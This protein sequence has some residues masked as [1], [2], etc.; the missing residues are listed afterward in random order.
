MRRVLLYSHDTFGLGHLRRCRTIAQALTARFDDLSALIVTGSPVVGRFDFGDRI[1]HVR[2]PGVV[3]LADGSYAAHNLG[4]GLDE[5]VDLRGSILKATMGSFDPNIV[6]VDKEPTGFKGELIPTLEAMA[7]RDDRTVILGIRDVLDERN[8]LALEWERK[9]AIDAL[10]A[11]YDEIW[12]YGL[13]EIYEPMKGLPLAESWSKRT[14]YTGYLRRDMVHDGSPNPVFDIFDKYILVTP[15]GGGDGAQ[16]IDWVL[17]AYE[18]DQSLT[19]PCIIVHGPFL[20]YQTRLSFDE[21]AA[22]MSDRVQTQG[23]NARMEQLLDGALGVVAMGGYNT[24]CEILSLDKPAVIEPRTSPRLEQFIRTEAAER[25]GLVRMIER[26]RDSAA[27]EA[28][29]KAIREL[30]HMP[31][32]S[33]RYQPGL[34]GGLETIVARTDF[35]LNRDPSP[36]AANA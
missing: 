17:S 35:W 3:K 34:L 36:L 15:G 26:S 11:Y 27:P 6:I 13:R 1:D 31:A 23:F 28:M 30:E 19:I 29:A 2:L 4:I 5:I 10:E 20:D 25:L 22:A 8:A 7:K 21:R 33:S 32:P 18:V 14:H 24:F 12:V 16:L 9:G